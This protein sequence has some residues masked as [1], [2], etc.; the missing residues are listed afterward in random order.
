MNGFASMLHWSHTPVKTKRRRARL[1]DGAL[2]VLLLA[3][4]IFHGDNLRSKH[5]WSYP[6]SIAIE[7]LIDSF[8]GLNSRK[9]LGFFMGA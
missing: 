3:E 9:K 8:M 1:P 5:P 6:G 4:G 7:L 2:L